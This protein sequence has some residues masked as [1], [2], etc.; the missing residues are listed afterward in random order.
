MFTR[1]RARSGAASLEAN[2]VERPRRLWRYRAANDGE[3]GAFGAVASRAD[4]QRKAGRV[5]GALSG[6][7]H[8][9]GSL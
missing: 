6:L 3:S 7:A 2:P 8:R 1:P 5:A 4:A 9:Y